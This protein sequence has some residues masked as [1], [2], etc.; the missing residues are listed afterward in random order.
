MDERLRSSIAMTF[1][2][3]SDKFLFH[4]LKRMFASGTFSFR[5]EQITHE[6]KL[7]IL[8]FPLNEYGRETARFIQTMVKLTFQRAWLRHPYVPG[9]CNG[10]ML[11]QDEFQ[12]L[13]HKQE[14]Y[15]AQ[16][17]RSSGVA[18]LY[19][20]QNIL[21]VAEEFGETQP[22]SKTRAF[23]NNLGLKLIHR[24][25]C[26]DTGA[27]FADVLGKRYR[28]VGNFGTTGG[29]ESGHSVSVG[30]SLQ[31]THVLDPINFTL[32]ARPNGTSPL[33]A[34]YCYRGGD[35]FN[36]SRTEKNPEGDQFL[37]VYFSR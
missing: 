20:T 34:A 11:V 14:N 36:A 28:P 16:T 22:G 10:G 7:L 5:P 29:H 37:K 12:M 17:A 19:I 35:I 26:P 1:A 9:C 15:W 3:L 33:A 4:P 18:S 2:G 8:D 31:L 24:S 13:L 32:L 6:K 27:Y 30:G 21:N 25:T 23:L